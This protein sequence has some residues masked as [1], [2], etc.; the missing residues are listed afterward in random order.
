[1]ARSSNSLL[2]RPRGK[3]TNKPCPF[4]AE[5]IRYQAV[6]CRY[7]GEF[8]YGDRKNSCPEPRDW[9]EVEVE[10]DEQDD[11]EYEEE[12]E[13]ELEEEDEDEQQDKDDDILYEGSPSIFAMTGRL[14][15]TLLVGTGVW[16][17]VTKPVFNTLAPYLGQDVTAQTLAQAERYLDYGALGLAAL[18]TLGFLFKLLVLKSTIYTVDAE[19]IEY[20][21]GIFC[22]EV[23]NIDMFR[24]VDLKLRRTLLDILVGIGT[25][26]VI[27]KDDSDPVFVFTKVRDC[28]YLYDHIRQAG[29]QADKDMK[30]VH[31]E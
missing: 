9:D 16:F 31:V 29:L 3:P 15:T 11:E 21:R 8:L 4:C 17:I 27:T 14:V 7:C 19:R 2:T 12:Y 18:V 24:V 22:R 6:K 5:L 1:M 25:I 20:R 28:R 26:T 23:D 30:V 13:E 10:E